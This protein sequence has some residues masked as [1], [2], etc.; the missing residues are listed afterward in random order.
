[1]NQISQIFLEGE[2][3]TLTYDDKISLFD[4][5]DVKIIVDVS[6]SYFEIVSLQS[7]SILM[8]FSNQK[9]QNTCSKNNRIFRT[10][11]YI[12]NKTCFEN[13][14]QLSTNFA[15]SSTTDVFQGPKY[16]T[17]Q[18]KILVYKEK[19]KVTLFFYFYIY[20]DWILFSI[21]VYN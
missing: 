9:H 5:V 11:P 10:V 8:N 19:F 18:S 21:S 20:L 15:Q 14:K 3:P 12:Y 13:S 7:M 4:L 17:E 1:M 2:S 6:Y 16:A